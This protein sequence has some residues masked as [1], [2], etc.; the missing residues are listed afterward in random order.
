M[1]R[2]IKSLVIFIFLIV[3]LFF[4][5]PRL[6]AVDVVINNFPTTITTDPFSISVSITGPSDATNY[7]RA[8]L[9]KDGS[10]NY[11]GETFNGNS[12]YAGSDGQNYFPIQ[13][14]N[15]S[16][17]ATFQAKIGSP[18]AGEYQGSGI[19]KLKIR[20]YT[21]SGNPASN[22]NQL[23]VAVQ[24]NYNLPTAQPTNAPTTAPTQKPATPIPTT[25][26]TPR[27]T[28]T[29]SPSPDPTD[30]PDETNKPE[31]LAVNTVE[32]ITKDIKINNFKNTFMIMSVVI[33]A[34]GIGFIAVASYMAYKIRYNSKNE[35]K[36]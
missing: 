16:A 14:I 28:P 9:Y 33:I 22:D 36:A 31:V 2:Y 10:T 12:W 1:N 32:P 29:K 21:S 30:I 34:L 8:D 18:N 24:I 13:I 25:S 7:L 11:F 6:L 23:P 5:P 15:S 17:S 3:L 26:S 19:Y 20:R 27:P 4:V 35:T